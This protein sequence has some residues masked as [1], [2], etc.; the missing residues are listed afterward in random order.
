MLPIALE[1]YGIPKDG[2]VLS[3]NPSLSVFFFS[4]PRSYDNC[5]EFDMIQEESCDRHCLMR[6]H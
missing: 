5:A 1:Y 4:Q 6:S 2:K 3:A